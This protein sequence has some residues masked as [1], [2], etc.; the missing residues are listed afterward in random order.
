MT[1]RAHLL[2]LGGTAEARAL[3]ALAV[4]RFGRRAR[5]TTSLA[6]R[7][8]APAPVAGAARRGGFGGAAGLARFLRR[9]G[10]DALVDATHPFA[11]RISAN[12]E[13][14]AAAAGV[15]RLVLRRP[16]WR[17]R[18]GDRWIVVADADAAARA[19]ARA[20]G[21]VLLT[22]GSGELGR[23]AGL[24]GRRLVA[25]MIERPP[26]DAL[27]AGARLLL[28]RGP[29]EL[30]GETTLL[31]RHRIAVVVAKA[32]G[33]DATRAKLDAARALGLTVILIRRPK[34]PAGPTAATPR[35]ALGW[36][37]TMLGLDG[38]GPRPD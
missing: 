5:V 16:A 7:T 38:V 37:A 14:A 34:P 9:G 21:R 31:R 20:R 13:A 2:I 36:V 6:G 30:A 24:P 22:V 8:R 10:V 26:R 19:A 25:R 35:A 18:P 11:A 4:A 33:G 15:P 12:A 27:P 29:F 28:A 17:R 32:S 1:R 23:F 3:A